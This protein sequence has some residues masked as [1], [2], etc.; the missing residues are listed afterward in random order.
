[1]RQSF[2]LIEVVLSGVVLLLVFIAS[3]LIM[4]HGAPYLVV[5]CFAAAAVLLFFIFRATMDP[6]R[7]RARQSERTLRLAAKTLPFMRQGLTTES[8]QAVCKLLLPAT[9]AS[10]VAITNRETIMG[11][12]GA[13]KE[14]HAIG[15]PIQTTATH[16][17]LDDGQIKVLKSQ[18]EIG[19]PR[20]YTTLQAAIIVPLTV[21][22]EPVG[23]LKFYFRSSKKID[24]TQRAMAQGLGALLEMQLQL[25]DLEY[26]RD[27]AIQMRLK[28]LQAQINPHFLFNTINT[29]ASLIRTNP[30]RARILLREFAAFYRHTLEGSFDLITLEQEYLQTLRYFGFEVARFGEERL[31][32]EREFAQGMSAIMVPAFVLQPLVENAIGHAMCDDRP[33]HIKVQALVVDGLAQIKVIDDGAGMS[34]NDQKQM[35]DPERE[36]AGIALRNVDERLR[37]FFGI[38][39]GLA[40]QSELGRGTTVSL[41]LGPY[42]QLKVI[43]NVKSDNS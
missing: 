27:L 37:G 25:A 4:T 5:L 31:N 30:A 14:S 28:A 9:L 35:L 3:A 11:F 24:E 13:E 43:E 16:A 18:D 10:A 1:M 6:D 23:V 22:E 2:S 26:Q 34:A 39:A 32:I 36:H 7:L 38:H 12:A 41:F 42:E 29:I 19:F 20:N 8:A 15:S 40:V 17:A 21:H 33:L